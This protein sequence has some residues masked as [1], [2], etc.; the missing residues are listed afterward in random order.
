MRWLATGFGRAG[1]L[2]SATPVP[3]SPK[4]HGSQKQGKEST[5]PGDISTHPPESPT[6]MSE[7]IKPADWL[8][9]SATHSLPHQLQAF[10]SSPWIFRSGEEG[11]VVSLT[12]P[13]RGSDATPVSVKARPQTERDGF[14]SETVGEDRETGGET[15]GLAPGG[16]LSREEEPGRGFPAKSQPGITE[17]TAPGFLLAEKKAPEVGV[18]EVVSLAPGMQAA[19]GPRGAAPVTKA[20][21]NAAHDLPP[22]SMAPSGGDD[23][24]EEADSAKTPFT[25]LPGLPNQIQTTKATETGSPLNSTL[26]LGDP[27]LKF[28]AVLGDTQTS[29]PA[30]LDAHS[31]LTPNPSPGRATTA[32]GPPQPSSPG[33]QGEP[34]PSE[35]PWTGITPETEPGVSDSTIISEAPHWDGVLEKDSRPLFSDP[36]PDPG[37]SPLSTRATGPPDDTASEEMAL[38]LDREG[39]LSPEHLPLLFEPLDDV[40]VVPEAMATGPPGGSLPASS[41]MRSEAEFDDMATVDLDRSLSEESIPELPDSTSLLWQISGSEIPDSVSPH[42]FPSL[43][44][45]PS[46]PP[47]QHRSPD[48]EEHGTA[49]TALEFHPIF[50]EAPPP[51]ATGPTLLT[52]VAKATGLSLTKP[53]SGLEELEYEEEHDEDEEDEET[54][55]S[56]EDESHEEETEAPMSAPTPP[57]Y[58]HV[59]RPPLWVQR[60]HGLVRSWVEKIRDEAGYVSGMLAPVGIGI[61]GALLILG[62]LYS[63][64]AVHRKRRNNIKQQR[65]KQREM[66][67][68]Q[69]QA[70]LLADSSEDEL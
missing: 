2:I 54:D 6:G 22:P 70:M 33:E 23:R 66:T 24:E 8:G 13:R 17:Q 31:P 50:I 64:R 20:A 5:F 38:G 15:E 47:L 49:D 34:G 25:R 28:T 63:I 21:D 51:S 55:D 67:S 48:S 43:T 16:S 57:T 27:E 44:V 62:I 40:D 1:F 29:T 18:L 9:R 65:R 11:T 26:A 36:D 56:E 53:K 4:V 39:T 42:V 41:R 35:P 58:S 30:A 45:S 59:P 52:T 69:D 46:G 14:V 10:N 32:E 19:S 3:P 61:A 12:E 7:S 60:N 37:L 68:R